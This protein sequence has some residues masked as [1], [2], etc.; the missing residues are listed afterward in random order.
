ME[1]QKNRNRNYQI[2]EHPSLDD[3][4]G[5]DA[6]KEKGYDENKIN[7]NYKNAQEILG[8]AQVIAQEFNNISDDNG[9]IYT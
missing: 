9:C 8:T 5:E 4:K 6:L 1:Q 3:V 7:I 2:V